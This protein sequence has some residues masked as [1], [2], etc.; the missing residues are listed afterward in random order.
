M[1]PC[2]DLSVCSFGQT[3]RPRLLRWWK[4]R[5]LSVFKA[6]FSAFATAPIGLLMISNPAATE[7]VKTNVLPDLVSS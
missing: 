1:P 5:I 4:K 2:G 7:L 3:P 6:L